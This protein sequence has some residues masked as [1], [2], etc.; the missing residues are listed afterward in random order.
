MESHFLSLLPST[1]NFLG[2][3]DL[4]FLILT[5]SFCNPIKS[6]WQR[7]WEFL[8]HCTIRLSMDFVNSSLVIFPLLLFQLS[9]GNE[10]NCLHVRLFHCEYWP[11]IMEL[12][13]Q[14]P[15]NFICT[16]KCMLSSFKLEK[17]WRFLILTLK[18]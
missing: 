7:H 4:K 8:L 11:K 2:N 1:S 16:R 15:M 3:P 17:S 14:I 9:N 12:S 10:H 13:Q 6:R 5:I 18:V